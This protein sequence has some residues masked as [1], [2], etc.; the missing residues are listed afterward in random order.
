MLIFSVKI[1]EKVIIDSGNIE[2][3]VNDVYKDRVK[4]G[5]TAPKNISIDREEIYRKKQLNK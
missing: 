1:G 2:V 4:L 5:F 3:T